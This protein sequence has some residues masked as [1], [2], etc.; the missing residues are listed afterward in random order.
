MRVLRFLTSTTL[1]CGC[2]VGVY[3]LYN[4]DVIGVVDEHP[5]SCDNPAH[6]GGHELSL[7]QLHLPGITA[8]VLAR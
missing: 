6:E 8:N 2:L 7:N 3:E 4:G 1:P 5:R